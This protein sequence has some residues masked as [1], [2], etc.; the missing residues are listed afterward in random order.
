MYPTIIFSLV[1]ATSLALLLAQVAVRH[2]TAVHLCFAVFCG[3]IAMMAAQQ[4][5]ADK[6]GAYQYLIGL[7]ACAT[8]NGFWLVAR[9]MFRV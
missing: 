4:L 2:K 5:S 6:V 3:S 7:G 9:A 1:L 8:C